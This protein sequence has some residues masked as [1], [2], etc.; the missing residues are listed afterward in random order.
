MWWTQWG[1]WSVG[2]AT[3]AVADMTRA[4]AGVGLGSAGLLAAL[5]LFW[6]GVRR[7][8]RTQSPRPAALEYPYAALLVALA[9]SVL[10]GTYS[11]ARK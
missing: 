2:T 11:P 8:R 5:A 3:V 10:V 4:V 7:A 6:I 1:L 9:C